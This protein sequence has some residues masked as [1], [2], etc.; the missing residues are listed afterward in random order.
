M[1]KMHTGAA[2]FPSAADTRAV[3][4]YAIDLIDELVAAIQA[5]TATFR[6][7]QGSEGPEAEK[8]T[9]AAVD[10]VNA[11]E[12]ALLALPSY[13]DALPLY[14]QALALSHKRW[15]VMEGCYQDP[16]SRGVCRM[17]DGVIAG[18]PFDQVPLLWH[19]S[20]SPRAERPSDDEL[21]AEWQ[22]AVSAAA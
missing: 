10:R 7:L 11:A 22:P 5:E 14:R 19:V 6:A 17:T 16:N 13:L 20:G 8:Q 9:D 18:T 2:G 12:R 4:S 3:M 1:G 21:Q 15:L